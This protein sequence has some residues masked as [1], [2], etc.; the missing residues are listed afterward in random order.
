MILNADRLVGW[1]NTRSGRRVV[2]DF[3]V[4]LGFAIAVRAVTFNMDLF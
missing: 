4:I 1:L 3:L 2:I